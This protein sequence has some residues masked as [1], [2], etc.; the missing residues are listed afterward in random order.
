[1]KITVKINQLVQIWHPKINLKTSKLHEYLSVILLAEMLSINKLY[2][3]NKNIH[4][5]S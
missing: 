5:K 1:M 3:Q 4:L 2:N